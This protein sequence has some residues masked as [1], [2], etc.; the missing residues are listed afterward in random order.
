ALRMEFTERERAEDERQTAQTELAHAAR[1]TTMGELVASIAHEVS[2]PLAAIVTSAS[3]SLRWLNAEPPN[4]PEARETTERIL[5][6][7]DRASD[8]LARI[9]RLLRKT[10]VRH[11][12]VSVNDLIRDT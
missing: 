8:V 11:E 6:D 10:A 5:R 4:L 9:R 7:G 12:R 2:Q 3:A 1:V